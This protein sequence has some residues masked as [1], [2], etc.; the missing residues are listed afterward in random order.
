MGAFGIFLRL[1]SIFWKPTLSNKSVKVLNHLCE[2]QVFTL[3]LDSLLV[4]NYITPN[5]RFTG[6]SWNAQVR[7]AGCPYLC[8]FPRYLGGIE[9]PSKLL[10]TT[11]MNIYLQ[12]LKKG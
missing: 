7:V 5:F 2:G 6:K 3:T 11:D 10:L 12:G 9:K 8:S 4:F 1:I